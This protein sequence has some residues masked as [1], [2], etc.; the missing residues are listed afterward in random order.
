MK[1]GQEG[2][3]RKGCFAEIFPDL[4]I[5]GGAVEDVATLRA[6]LCPSQTSS[7]TSTQVPQFAVTF[8]RRLKIC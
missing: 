5:K 7:Q 8:K 3:A 6:A 4:L 1:L 2:S